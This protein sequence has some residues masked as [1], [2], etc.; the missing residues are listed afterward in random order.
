MLKEKEK[1]SKRK[2]IELELECLEQDLLDALKHLD[3]IKRC[4]RKKRK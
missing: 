4:K 3:R 1:L 2:Y